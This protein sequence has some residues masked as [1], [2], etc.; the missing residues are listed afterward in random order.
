MTSSYDVINDVII[1][2]ITTIDKVSNDRYTQKKVYAVSAFPASIY[3]VGQCWIYG[4]FDGSANIL[5]RYGFH[6]INYRPVYS[7]VLKK[8]NFVTLLTRA[9]R[10]FYFTIK[11]LELMVGYHRIRRYRGKV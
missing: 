8:N 7:H 3:K 4:S 11:A 2:I 5:G 1:I 9:F 6:K 10:S